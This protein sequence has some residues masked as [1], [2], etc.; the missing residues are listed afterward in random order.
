M[1][2]LIDYTNDALTKAFE[3]AGAF[4]AFSNKQFSER[5]KEGVEYA[6]LGAGLI[7]PKDKCAWLLQ[8]MEKI[9]DKGIAKD[10]KENGKEAIIK[11]ELA[12]HE[13][14]Y[15]GDPQ[16]CVDKLE[17][18]PI[19]EEEILRVFQGQSLEECHAV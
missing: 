1:K 9:T 10:L 15:T 3:E 19:T 8:E 6:S 18:Y 13:C 4:F 14:Y 5:Q 17:Y 11:R 16:D 2:Y 12:N 7:C